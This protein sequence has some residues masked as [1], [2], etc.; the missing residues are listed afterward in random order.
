MV[1]RK[2]AASTAWL[3]FLVQ[4]SPLAVCSS[5]LDLIKNDDCFDVVETNECGLSAYL[6][7][8]GLSD[9]HWI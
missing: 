3:C 7:G 6:L 2:L 4:D 9:N 1:P 8:L 5:L